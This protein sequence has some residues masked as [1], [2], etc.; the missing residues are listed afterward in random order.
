MHHEKLNR[1]PGRGSTCFESE[2]I[3]TGRSNLFGPLLTI[4]LTG[5]ITKPT[6]QASEESGIGQ[7]KFELVQYSLNHRKQGKFFVPIMYQFNSCPH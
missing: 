2:L 4:G 6:I 7:F 3:S 1:P 5:S